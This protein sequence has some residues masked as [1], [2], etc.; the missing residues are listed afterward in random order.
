M[1]A[2]TLRRIGEGS[3]WGIIRANS[4]GGN[5]ALVFSPGIYD[6]LCGWDWLLGRPHPQEECHF[7]ITAHGCH[8]SATVN[9][10]AHKG[11]IVQE[12]SRAALAARVRP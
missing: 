12:I 2:V 1:E 4:A 7:E 3:R 11:K 10:D 5:G 8:F 6:P 9:P